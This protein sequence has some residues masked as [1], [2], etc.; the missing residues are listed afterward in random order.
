[1]TKALH[2]QIPPN[3]EWYPAK[4]REAEVVRRY[5]QA[6]ESVPENKKLAEKQTTGGAL[7]S[8]VT[9]DDSIR[10]SNPME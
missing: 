4:K 8:V 3:K 2:S 6:S 7:H 10:H 9:I 5:L 1:M